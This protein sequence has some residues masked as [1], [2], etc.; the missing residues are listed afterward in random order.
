MR[1]SFRSS[2][3]KIIPLSIAKDLNS[4]PS[5]ITKLSDILDICYVS[6]D[7]D[8]VAIIDMS[9]RESSEGRPECKFVQNVI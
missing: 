1:L 8:Y 4:F 9:C 6:Y 7:F 5:K 3:A 2:S